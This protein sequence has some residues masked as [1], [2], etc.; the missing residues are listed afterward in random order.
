[1]RW[2]VETLNVVDRE[3]EELPPS[4]QARLIRLLEMIETVGPPQM[5]EPHV[6]HVEGSSGSCG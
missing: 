3:I 5:R 6:K 1:M 2:T 4:L